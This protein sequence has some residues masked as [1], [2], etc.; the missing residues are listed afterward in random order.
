MNTF[1]TI[2]NHTLNKPVLPSKLPGTC[3]KDLPCSLWAFGGG[4]VGL[5]RSPDSVASPST[6]W[7]LPCH[8]GGCWFRYLWN[9]QNSGIR[10]RWWCGFQCSRLCW[11]L[12]REQLP[13]PLL[14]GPMVY[15]SII[16]NKHW[17]DSQQGLDL[18]SQ[19][20]SLFFLFPLFLFLSL[21]PLSSLPSCFS[22]WGYGRNCIAD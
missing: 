11:T 9:N 14:A 19:S 2:A 22:L 3:M 20:L 5:G 12:E 8:F 18:M 21:P 7:Q 17:L 16:P 4:G 10:R 6:L 13:P 15:L 1:S